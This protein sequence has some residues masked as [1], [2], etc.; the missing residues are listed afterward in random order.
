[1]PKSR[2]SSGGRGSASRRPGS[3]GSAP[4]ASGSRSSGS[5]QNGAAPRANGSGGSAP[6]TSESRQSSSKK[7]TSKPPPRSK[8]PV[9]R[10][11]PNLV[12]M[13]ETSMNK[14]EDNAIKSTI[15][16]VRITCRSPP[17]FVLLYSTI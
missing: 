12:T 9:R 2:Q 6:K 13:I 11:P 5:Q 15:S 17:Y 8:Q 14:L 16:P 3:K 7:T 4:K 10:K 1:M